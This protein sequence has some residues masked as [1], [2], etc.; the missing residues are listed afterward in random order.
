MNIQVSNLSL[1]V[2]DSDLK[3]LF[4]AYGEVSSVVIIRNKLNGRSKGSAMIDM[5]NDAQAR[6]A[7]LSLDQTVLDGKSITVSEI[8]YSIRDNK[9]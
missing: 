9:N 3:K 5:V 1:H 6:Q 2:I 8:R 7:I 4:E